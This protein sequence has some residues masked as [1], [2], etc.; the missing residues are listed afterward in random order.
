MKSLVAALRTLVLPWGRTTG[1]RIVLDGVNGRILIYDANDVVIAEISPTIDPDGNTPGGFW[2]RGFQSPD[3]IYSFLGGGLVVMGPIPETVCDEHSYLIYQTDS[4][5]SPQ[6]AAST[7]SSG[8]PDS[9]YNPARLQLVGQDTQ[10]P[11]AYIDGGS[12]ADRADLNVTGVFRSNNHTFGRVTITPVANTPTSTTV[13]FGF[14]MAGTVF[15]GFATANTTVIGSTVQGVAVSS[16]GATSMLVWVY[17]TNT[18]NTN[19]DWEAWSA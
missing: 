10:W 7:L 6:Y 9:T 4:G 2:T 16:V 17:R 5:F 11:Q 8:V 1:T 15:R 3:P 12:I 13:N 18:T 19:V 14:T